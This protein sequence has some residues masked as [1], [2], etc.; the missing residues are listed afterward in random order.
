MQRIGVLLLLLVACFSTAMRAQAP[1][2]KPDPALKT[3]SVFLGHWTCEAESKAGPLGPGGKVTSEES[4]QMILGGFFQQVRGADKGPT[5]GQSLEI[6]RYDPVNK[7]FPFS[8]Y[9]NDGSTWSGVFSGSGNTLTSTGKGIV[10]GNQGLFRG[11]DVFAA[12]LMSRTGK[13]EISTDDGKTWIPFNESKCTKVKPAP[14][15]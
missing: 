8:G 12:D 13:V 5:G 7:N 10:G 6:A 14:K 15:K 4:I 9:S 1:A 3:L 11:T 2:P